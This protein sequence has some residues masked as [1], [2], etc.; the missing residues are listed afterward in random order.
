MTVSVVH[1]LEVIRVE[2][3]QRKG[4][5]HALP[6]LHLVFGSLEKRATVGEPCQV[7]ARH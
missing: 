5:G 3:H 7:I 6:A 2:Q 1:G 4:S